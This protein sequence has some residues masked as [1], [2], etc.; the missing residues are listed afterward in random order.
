MSETQSYKTVSFTFGEA[1]MV[2]ISLVQRI[3]L[4]R[5]RIARSDGLVSEV[6]SAELMLTLAAL[7]KLNAA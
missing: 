7:D 2:E 4:L 5:K 3:D 6:H 1:A